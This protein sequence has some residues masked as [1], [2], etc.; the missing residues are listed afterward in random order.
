MKPK[1][2]IYTEPDSWQFYE[3]RDNGSCYWVGYILFSGGG[4]MSSY[5][6]EKLKQQKAIK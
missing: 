5:M 4:N 3:V 2:R 6:T 1:Y